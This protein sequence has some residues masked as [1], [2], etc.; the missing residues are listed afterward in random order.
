MPGE[1]TEISKEDTGKVL[2]QIISRLRDQRF[3]FLIAVIVAL[4]VLAPLKVVSSVSVIIIFGISAGVVLV[5]RILES[6]G[7]RSRR[8]GSQAGGLAM[9]V[10]PDFEGVAEGAAIRL[11]SGVCTIQNSRNPGQVIVREVLP[12]PGP[13]A[14]GWLCPIPSEAGSDDV[15][16]ITLTDS[17]GGRWGMVLVPGH[18]W[19]SVKAERLP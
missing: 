2:G 15:V 12:Y 14:L 5:D 18:L 1:L 6:F 13:G 4:A 10:A 3:L 11:I 7:P 17:G 19:P 16:N 8:A 9:S